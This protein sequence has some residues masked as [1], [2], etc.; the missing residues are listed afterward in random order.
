[1]RGFAQEVVRRW[2]EPD[3]GIWEIRGDLVHHVHSKVMAWLALDRALRLA[4]HHRVP[5]RRRQQW[6]AER[7]A[8]AAEVRERGF[9]P[10]R[11]TYVRSYGSSELDA[12]QLML[13]VVGMDPP[14]CPA[15]VSTV[16][17]IRR[18]LGA[19]GP[20]LYRYP[21]GSDGLEG[22]E[23]AFL[24]CSFWLVQA[25]ALT[26]RRG[27]AEGAFEDA[28]ALGGPLGL[29]AEEMDPTSGRQLGNFPQALTHAAVVQ[30]A[31]ALRDTA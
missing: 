1:M 27:Q 15:V 10:L 16:D 7:D 26:G 14:D 17:A 31:L 6:R 8:L 2:R 18:E 21:P 28:M 13:P 20:L 29:W 19:G 3:A 23:G 25:L 4:E 30:A 11:G 9:D 22:P 24:P 5:G 12:A